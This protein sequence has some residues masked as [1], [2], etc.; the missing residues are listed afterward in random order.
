MWFSRHRISFRRTD[1]SLYRLDTDDIEEKQSFWGRLFRRR[2]LGKQEDF[3]RY[4]AADG[5]RDRRHDGE[6]FLQQR[7]VQRY[8]RAVLLIALIWLLGHFIP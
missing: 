3:S 6:E 4:I 1:R 7:S 2:Q 5:A 8:T